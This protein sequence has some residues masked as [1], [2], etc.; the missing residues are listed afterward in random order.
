MKIYRNN[1]IVAII[2]SIAVALSLSAYTPNKAEKPSETAIERT[3]GYTSNTMGRLGAA[4]Q[5]A[6]EHLEQKLADKTIQEYLNA[7]S[8]EIKNFY[9][10]PVE[11]FNSEELMT[12]YERIK[13]ETEKLFD[14]IFNGK[15]INGYTFKDLSDSGKEKAKEGLNMA[16][17]FIE[18]YIPDYKER[19]H[20]WTVD[21]GADAVEL[22]EN[23]Q[24][25]YNGYKDEVLEEHDR[26]LTE[27]AANIIKRK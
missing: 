12:K 5:E 3:V 9:S 15:D 14:F 19:F 23:L 16:D 24:K 26:R 25:W 17:E 21:K 13:E 6:E 8:D 22:W 11:Y 1:K 18:K 20:D 7:L 2:G 4:V 27:N 10:S